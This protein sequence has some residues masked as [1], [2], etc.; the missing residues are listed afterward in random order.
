MPDIPHHP[1]DHFFKRAFMELRVVK[2]FIEKYVPQEFLS[3]VNLNTLQIEKGTF[4]T[5]NYQH[6]ETDMLYSVQYQDKRAYFYILCEMQ[7]QI[8]KT[9]ALR[10]NGYLHHF[11]ELYS[12]QHPKTEFPI[13]YPMIIYAGKTTWKGALNFFDLFGKNRPIMQ[14]IYLNEIQL[15][16]IY[17]LDDHLIEQHRWVGLFEFVLKYRKMQDIRN[18]IDKIIRWIAEVES[19]QNRDYAVLVIDY[20]MSEFETEDANYFID[21]ANTYFS[22]ALRGDIMTIA[23]YLR[24]EG[25]QE[26]RLEGRL[27]GIKEGREEGKLETLRL[28]TKKLENS[29]FSEQ[30]I[31]KIIQLSDKELEK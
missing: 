18:V 10:I 30:E 2:D 13:I 29:G 7:A 21:S 26:G 9:I 11:F 3:K 12:K 1:T 15:I 27:E 16:D 28:I 4:V 25:R 22:E 31:L 14:E 24:R 19:N 6:R 23:Q 5:A 8:D 20:I 17:R